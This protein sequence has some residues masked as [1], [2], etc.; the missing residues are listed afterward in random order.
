MYN[1]IMIRIKSIILISLILGVISQ[2]IYADCNKPIKIAV[3]DTGFGFKGLGKNAKLCQEGHRDFSADQIYSNKYNT[4]DPI[5]VDIHGH[6]TNIAGII[7]HYV[8]QKGLNYCLVIIK[9]YSTKNFE[10]ENPKLDYAIANQHGSEKSLQYLAQ[11]DP[12]ITNV[13]GGGAGY[14][15]IESRAVK[16]YL[17]SGGILV[18][19][20]GNIGKKLS[21]SNTSDLYT[22][23]YPAMYDPRI[24]VVGSIN[25][26]GSRSTFSNYGPFVKRWEE[27][28]NVTGYGLV[29]S[30]TSQ[31][32]AIAT[33][34]IAGQLTN[35]CVK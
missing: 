23:Y 30:G 25:D 33:G 17:N 18:A 12:T 19:A 24:V 14:D 34:K 20:A 11:L 16:S 27:G 22:T 5:P 21:N 15:T 13:S 1:H 26:N 9:F 2:N 6:G 3:I 28:L 8:N 31:A 4:K 10:S 32:T 7:E 29:F 35:K